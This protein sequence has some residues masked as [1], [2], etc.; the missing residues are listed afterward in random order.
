MTLRNIALTFV[1][2]MLA[3]SCADPQLPRS[4]SEIPLDQHE[5]TTHVAQQFMNASPELQVTVK[6]PLRLS[7]ATPRRPG[8][9]QANLDRIWSYCVRDTFRC[10]AIVSEYVRGTMS[11]LDIDDAPLDR[12]RIRAVVRPPEYATYIRSTFAN[13]P[14]ELPPIRP[15]AGGLWLVLVADYP[16][17]T[18][19]ITNRDLEILGLTVEEAIRTAKTNLATA[20]RPPAIGYPQIA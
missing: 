9:T 15:I 6:G 12:A 20:L 2:A 8:T 18:R 7:V 10:A 17:A 13:P 3:A 19:T 11:S 5:F 1:S 16:R 14:N 4:S